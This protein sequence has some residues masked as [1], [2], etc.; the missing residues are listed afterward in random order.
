MI[1]GLEFACVPYRREKP[2]S[3]GVGYT[4]LKSFFIFHSISISLSAFCVPSTGLGTRN[5]KVTLAQV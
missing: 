4:V 2:I 3:E 1:G 5:S